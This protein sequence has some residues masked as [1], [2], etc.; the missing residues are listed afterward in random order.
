MLSPKIV[1]IS[2][3]LTEAFAKF[4]RSQSR[5]RMQRH[6][7]LREPCPPNYTWDWT[8]IRS[9]LAAKVRRLGIT[10]CKHS[11]GKQCRDSLHDRD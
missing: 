3:E 5:E 8:R 2:P 1:T 4:P 9:V 11:G 6:P 7:L 10:A